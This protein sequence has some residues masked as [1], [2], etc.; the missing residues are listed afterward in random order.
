VNR[1]LTITVSEEVYRG[2]TLN[3]E[4]RKAM[5][6]QIATVL[7]LRLQSKLGVLSGSDLRAL[8]QAI[9]VQL[10]LVLRPE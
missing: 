6:D 1:K 8:E 9:A 2:L 3:G 7:K 5:T 10:G 4:R